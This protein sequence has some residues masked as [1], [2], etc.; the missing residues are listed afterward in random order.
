M[1]TFDAEAFA[2]LFSIK[3]PVLKDGATRT[4][5]LDM[6]NNLTAPHPAE[7][8]QWLQMAEF[9]AFAFDNLLVD[10]VETWAG[11]RTHVQPLWIFL[12][13]GKFIATMLGQDKFECTIGGTRYQCP[14]PEE[15]MDLEHR[16]DEWAYESE[17]MSI[18]M[19][20]EYR[21]SLI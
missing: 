2:F 7:I 15:K 20:Y 10:C 21:D 3:E 16:Y 6:M 4:R 17:E 13:L 14:R 9:R 8:M 11:Y 12:L 1:P 5:L 18:D 19:P